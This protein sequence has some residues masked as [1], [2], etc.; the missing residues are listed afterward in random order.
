MQVT[1]DGPAPGVIVE[2]RFHE[3]TASLPKRHMTK[4]VG[5]SAYQATIQEHKAGTK[6][7]RGKAV[8]RWAEANA[9]WFAEAAHA[10]LLLEMP[11]GTTY[12]RVEWKRE[13]AATGKLKA[14]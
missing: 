4:A 8:Q 12:H 14:R 6:D 1:I 9:P 3:R 2:T 10:T 11:D 7:R 5:A 13:A